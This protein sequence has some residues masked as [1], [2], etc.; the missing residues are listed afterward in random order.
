LFINSIKKIKIGGIKIFKFKIKELI[1]LGRFRFLAGGFLLYAMGF[2]LASLSINNFSLTLFLFGYAIMLPGHL[3]L[4]YSNNYFDF[5][6]DRFNKPNLFSGGSRVLIDNPDLRKISIFIAIALMGVSVII[7]VIFVFLYS[8]SYFLI[9]FVIFANLL[10]FFYSA[11]P[12]R[13]AYKGLGEIANMITMGII[14]PGIGYWIAK[15]GLDSLFFIFATVF[16]LYGLHFIISVELPDM[17]GDLK[18]KKYTLV[19]RLGRKT[20]YRILILS[21]LSASIFLMFFSAIN[22]VSN[23]INLFIIFLLSFIPLIIGLSGLLKKPFTKT[24]SIIITRNNIFAL[25]GFIFTINI[26]LIFSLILS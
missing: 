2:L 18:A 15:G 17:E 13:L 7:S 10:G 22:I 9:L 25:I 21:I 6:G 8:F 20:S 24:N 11:P 1:E 3:G 5:K 26:Y 12:L 14:M 19:T 4:S 23:S 16:L